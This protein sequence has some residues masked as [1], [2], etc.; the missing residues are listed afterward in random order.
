MTGYTDLQRDKAL[1]RALKW[2]KLF[3]KKNFDDI[4]NAIYPVADKVK[5]DAACNNIPGLTPEEKA[6]LWNYLK[7]CNDLWNPTNVLEAA[8]GTPW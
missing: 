1:H 7:N 8:A 6:W 2:T 5:F 3:Q 4:L